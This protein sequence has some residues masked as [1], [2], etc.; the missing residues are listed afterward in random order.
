MNA[1]RFFKAYHVRPTPQA[2]WLY[3][4]EDGETAVVKINK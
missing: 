2:G 4:K 1:A 3:L